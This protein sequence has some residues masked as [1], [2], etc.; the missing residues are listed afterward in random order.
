MW[1]RAG[2]GLLIPALE[3]KTNLFHF[4]CLNNTGAIDVEMDGSVFEEK[5]SF[6]VLVLPFSS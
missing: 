3:K 2:S 6:Q 5:S 4:H 1:T